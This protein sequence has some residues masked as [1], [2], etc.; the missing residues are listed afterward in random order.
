VLLCPCAIVYRFVLFVLGVGRK[1]IGAAAR[2]RERRFAVSSALFAKWY[3][4]PV[5]C[6]YYFSPNILSK[7]TGARELY[8]L[9]LGPPLFMQST[10][11]LRIMQPS[12]LRFRSDRN[13]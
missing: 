5:T 8:S 13:G 4:H 2:A 12:P 3:F 9:T 6:G 1:R 7:N 11:L 10:S